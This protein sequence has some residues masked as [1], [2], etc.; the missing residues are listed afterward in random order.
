MREK[1]SPCIFVAEI[2]ILASHII[3]KSKVY[4]RPIRSNIDYTLDEETVGMILRKNIHFPATAIKES[5]LCSS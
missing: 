1:K 5:L 4:I 3:F 2:L